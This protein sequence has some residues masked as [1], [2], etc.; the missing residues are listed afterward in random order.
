ME[1]FHLLVTKRSKHPKKI[2]EKRLHIQRIRKT[3]P[4]RWEFILDRCKQVEKSESFN[5]SRNILIKKNV[6]Y[7][8]SLNRFSKNKIDIGISM[9]SESPKIVNYLSFSSSLF[10]NGS[11]TGFKSFLFIFLLWMRAI[12]SWHLWYMY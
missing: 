10:T 4:R 2:S 12:F 1:E 7:E 5:D 8:R 11:W 9:F 6:C 3:R